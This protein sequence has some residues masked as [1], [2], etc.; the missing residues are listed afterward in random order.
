MGTTQQMTRQED[1]TIWIM[2]IIYMEIK[3]Y[4]IKSQSYKVSFT[5]PT[6][7]FKYRQVVV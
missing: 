3:Y 7:H 4:Y 1:L 5:L 2:A 6:I